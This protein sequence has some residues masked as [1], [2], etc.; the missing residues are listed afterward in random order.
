M[1]EIAYAV[2]GFLTVRRDS[3]R[4]PLRG[5]L[6]LGFD[7]EPGPVTGDLALDESAMTRTVFG[8]TLLKTGVQ[9]IPESGIAGRF[10]QNG[11]LSATVTVNAVLT[12]VHAAGRRLLTGRTC[13]TARSC[14]VP[15]RS[16]PGE[17]N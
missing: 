11:Q 15:L 5:T 3:L 12:A 17:D 1:R 16:R 9:I 4:V 14:V 6:T 10:D 8:I 7:Q 13:R 2:Q